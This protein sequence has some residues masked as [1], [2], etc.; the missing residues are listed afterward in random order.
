MKYF[1]LL[2]LLLLFSCS[3]TQEIPEEYQYLFYK[4]KN[5]NQ[6]LLQ[7][8]HPR[9]APQPPKFTVT[10]SPEL[11]TQELTFIVKAE[12][13]RTVEVRKI[14]FFYDTKNIILNYDANDRALEINPASKSL[15]KQT[16]LA[17]NS[18]LK[19]TN[20]VISALGVLKSKSGPSLSC[21]GFFIGKGRF[22]TNHHCVA[23]IKNCNHLEILVRDKNQQIRAFKCLGLDKIDSTLDLAVL[24]SDRPAQDYLP[25]VLKQDQTAFVDNRHVWAI[26]F[27]DNKLTVR[28][29]LS[30]AEERSGRATG[31]CLKQYG[32]KLASFVHSCSLKTEPGDSGSPIVN[33]KGQV[34]GL[35]WGSADRP[36]GQL[37]LFSPSHLLKP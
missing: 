23:K 35:L 33:S 28:K 16:P 20:Q 21:S 18:H 8:K 29:C 14:Q 4:T 12:P 1:R 26:N 3:H 19:M 6:V 37:S 17:L 30:F 2:G 22:V 36:S 7:Q 13:I 5:S 25:L 31:I 32:C 10:L 9:H 24:I 34:L 15:E 27:R 11:E